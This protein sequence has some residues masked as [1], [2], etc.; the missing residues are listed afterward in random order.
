MNL[1]GATAAII[2]SRNGARQRFVSLGGIFQ[3]VFDK[4]ITQVFWTSVSKKWRIF[5]GFF[6]TFRSCKDG[7]VLFNG[8]TK[9]WKTRIIGG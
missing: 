1:Q 5:E 8:V 7:K 6:A 2:T 4:K 3:F 9:I